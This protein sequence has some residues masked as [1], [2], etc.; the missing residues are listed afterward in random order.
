MPKQEVA[1]QSAAID[2]AQPTPLRGLSI[3]SAKKLATIRIAK[4]GGEE[5]ETCLINS[6]D[7]DEDKHGP[8]IADKLPTRKKKAKK[9]KVSKET[10]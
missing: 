2:T 1:G 9:K 4:P 6:A 3:K 5:G 7:Y 8:V 10:D